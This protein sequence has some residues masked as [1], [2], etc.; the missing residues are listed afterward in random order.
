MSIGLD[1][2]DVRMLS[3][4]TNWSSNNGMDWRKLFSLA[5]ELARQIWLLDAWGTTTFYA[6]G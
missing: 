1:K 2:K 3:A 5:E 4:F 6:D